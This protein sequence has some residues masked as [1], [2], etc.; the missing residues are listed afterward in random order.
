MKSVIVPTWNAGTLIDECLA[1]VRDQLTAAD[2]L[3]VID[4]GSHDGTPDRIAA[5]YPPVKLVRLPH[6]LGFAGGVNRGLQLAQGDEMILINQ[7]VVLRPG[8]L[9]ALSAQLAHGPAIVGCKLLY[10]DG[11]TLQHAGGIIHWPRAI[12]D[13]YGYRQSDDGRWDSVRDVDY[14]TGAVLALNRAVLNTIGLLDEGF[15]PAY[16]EEVDYAFRARAA[17]ARVIYEP[18]AIAIHHESQS[19]DKRTA[20]YHRAMERGRLRLVLKH[21]PPDQFFTAFMPAELDYV[22]QV[23][24]SFARDVSAPA[25]DETLTNLPPLPPESSA[26]MVAALR[27]LRATAR[28]NVTRPSLATAVPIPP[29]SHQPPISSEVPMPE[30][31]PLLDVPPLRE[32]EFQ[33]NAPVVGPLIVGVRRALYSLTA[34][35]PLRVALD[36]QTRINQQLTQR[37]LEHEG[38]LYDHEARLQSAEVRLQSVEARLQSVEARLLAAE[39]QQRDMET[40]LQEY[41]ERLIDQD[42]D[43]ARLSRVTAEVELRQRRLSTSALAP[44]A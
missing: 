38:R 7:D 28:Q 14:V 27:Q 31:F 6:N 36:Q 25:Y 11:V 21:L 20:A 13:H 33:S 40:R 26:D 32:H 34:K 9:A 12:A 29:A 23:D 35:W 43:L 22:R 19:S 17:G 5:Q 37:L 39:A 1:S 18:A 24:P 16:Y 42:H 2:E 41:D 44:H 10:P 4:N 8:C 3:I 30:P 15:F